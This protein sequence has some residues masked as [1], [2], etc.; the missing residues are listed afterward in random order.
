MATAL[1]LRESIRVLPSAGGF[2]YGPIEVGAGQTTGCR[3]FLLD[4]FSLAW[5]LEPSAI[6]PQSAKVPGSYYPFES[7]IT[8]LKANAFALHRP[9]P[10]T[11]NMVRNTTYLSDNLFYCWG[12]GATLREARADYASNLVEEYQDLLANRDSLSRL[13]T[14]RLKTLEQYIAKR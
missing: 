13:A 5:V 3:H 11:V 4:G 14:S 12:S 7:E 8:K 1:Y 10:V 2:D 9:I 6:R